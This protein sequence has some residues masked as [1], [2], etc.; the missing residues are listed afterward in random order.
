[1]SPPLSADPINFAG[2]PRVS[3]DEP[4]AIDGAVRAYMFSPRERG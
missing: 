1:M 3:G 2:F 4:R